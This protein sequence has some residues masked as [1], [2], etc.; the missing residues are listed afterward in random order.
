M[1]PQVFLPE[2]LHPDQPFLVIMKIDQGRVNADSVQ[3]ISDCDKSEI[4]RF[5]FLVFYQDQRGIGAES[6]PVI[7]AI[8]TSLFES[9]DI[10]GQIVIM[11]KA[12][13][14]IINEQIQR[15]TKSVCQKVPVPTSTPATTHSL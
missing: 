12:L 10:E 8:C 2:V 15:H 9:A 4:F 6:N 11:R 13:P 5:I 3:K 7:F 1:M 14:S